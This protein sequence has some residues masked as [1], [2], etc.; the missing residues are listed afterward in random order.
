MNPLIT[1]RVRRAVAADAPHVQRLYAILVQNPALD[2]RAERLAHIAGDPAAALFVHDGAEGVDGT[3]F[4][5]LCAD[6]M[7]GDQP[8]AVVENIVVEPRAR[9]RGVGAALMRAVDA[10]CRAARC[11]K[12]MLLSAAS[13]AEAH[14]FFE[15]CGYAGSVKKGFVKYARDFG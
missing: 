8:F 4:V 2:V 13:R 3:V 5:A 12:I 10:H 15:R 7:F 6:A 9:G 11:S 14:A 1:D